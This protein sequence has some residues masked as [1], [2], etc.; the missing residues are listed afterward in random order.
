MFGLVCQIKYNGEVKQI[1]FFE[2]VQILEGMEILVFSK[3]FH[4]GF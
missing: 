4:A 2:L 3:C 1:L